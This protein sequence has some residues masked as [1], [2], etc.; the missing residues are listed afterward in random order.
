MPAHGDV[1]GLPQPRP[2]L[3]GGALHALPRGSEAVREAG[4][5]LHARGQLPRRPTASGRMASVT[6]CSSCHDQ[7]MC[8]QCHTATTRPMPPSIQFP[9][10]VTVRVHPPRRLDLP[11][12]HR[13]GG[14]TRPAA[15]SA[16]ARATARAATP[17]RGSPRAA[18]RIRDPHPAGWISVHGQA[19]RQNILSCAGCHNQGANSLCVACHT[20]GRVNPHPPGWKGTQAQIGVEPDVQGLPHAVAPEWRIAFVPAGRRAAGRSRTPLSAPLVLAAEGAPGGSKARCGGCA[21]RD[22]RAG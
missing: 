10:K 4:E 8:S 20:S 1:H 21:M 14:P 11:P 22:A 9:E 15:R 16:T 2:G 12:R 5:G 13:A 7:T 19:A 17:S 18:P 6:T 3:R